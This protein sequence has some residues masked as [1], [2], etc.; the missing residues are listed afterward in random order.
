MAAPKARKPAGKPGSARPA[1]TKELR[2]W[3]LVAFI[4]VGLIIAGVFV[5]VGYAKK[6]HDEYGQWPWARSAVPPQMYYDHKHYKS[7]GAGSLTGVIQVGKNPGGGIIYA[8]NAD[9]KNAPAT[10]QVKQPSTGKV[11]AYSLVTTP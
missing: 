8:V 5:G 6:S 3:Q 11:F 10:I 2:P 9:K 1:P 7:A 4:L